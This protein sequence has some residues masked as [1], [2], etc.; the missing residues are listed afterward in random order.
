M[1]EQTGS[2]KRGAGLA[3]GSL[4]VLAACGA[5]DEGAPSFAADAPIV[6]ESVPVDGEVG[7]DADLEQITATFSEAMRTEGW[8]W[9]SEAG[10]SKPSIT[11]V[12]FY[13]DATTTVLPVRLQP[14]TTYVIWVNSPD[15][16]ELRKFESSDGV[17][18]R[19]HRIRFSTR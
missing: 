18:A 8:S 12:P 3:M 16:G 7:V 10:R 4:L 15:D 17:T 9:V 19:A 14:Q 6:I 11:G 1:L 5:G 2:D 13:L